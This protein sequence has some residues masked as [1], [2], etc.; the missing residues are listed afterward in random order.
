MKEKPILFSGPMIPALL[1][2]RPNTWPAEAIDPGKPY[3]WMTRRVVNRVY[4]TVPV[5]EFE[6]SDTPGYD[7]HFR[8]KHLRWHEVN[9]IIPP[10]QKRDILW[11]RQTWRCVGYN[12]AK[13]TINF[14]YKCADDEGH[15]GLLVQFPD[16]TRFK[17][18][19]AYCEGGRGWHP[20]IFLPR[21][22]SRLFLEVKDVRVER[23]QE[24]TDKAIRAEGWPDTVIFDHIETRFIG[25]YCDAASFCTKE[26]KVCSPD[27]CHDQNCFSA[28]WNTLNGKRG[29][30]WENNPYVYVYE[31]MRVP[32]RR[33]NE[34]IIA[35]TA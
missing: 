29:Y 14:E 33:C 2:T 8:D 16:I 15:A 34:H 10:Y 9:Y 31:F 12:E 30:A 27:F 18:Y 3:K 7:W 24:I 1:N 19:A 28:F 17:K 11:V 20:S 22:A 26:N 21:E 13:Q 23:I 4:G 6:K 32:M 35:G 5:T 25:P